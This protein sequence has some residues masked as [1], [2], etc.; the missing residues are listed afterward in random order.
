M[1]R[2]Y[3]TDYY[4]HRIQVFDSNTNF[5]LKYGIPGTGDGQFNQPGGI[6]VDGNENIYVADTF[7][8]RIQK[9]TRALKIKLTFKQADVADE[10]PGTFETFSDSVKVYKNVPDSP[11]L[12][13]HVALDSFLHVTHK[14]ITSRQLTSL[15]PFIDEFSSDDSLLRQGTYTKVPA[16]LS[17]K[18]SIS[19]GELLSDLLGTDKLIIPQKFPTWQ[20]YQF[21]VYIKKVN[22]TALDFSLL[23]KVTD[24]NNY[25]E[26]KL[27]EGEEETVHKIV[28]GD[29][30]TTIPNTGVD[31]SDSEFWGKF[32]DFIP[33]KIEIRYHKSSGNTF[34]KAF[35]DGQEINNFIYNIPVFGGVGIKA[36]NTEI[37][38]DRL[39]IKPLR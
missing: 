30:E 38:V 28:A 39:E 23:Y 5:I 20:D 11:Y 31:N 19:G 24:L 37:A 8:H 36:Y 18:W 1:G 14:Q 7:N 10:D 3:V 32:S 12:T 27:D 25:Y 17:S 21:T 33:V 4:N 35:I 16:G 6:A 34:V 22:G 2:V 26:F 9:F 13:F 15:V 29:N